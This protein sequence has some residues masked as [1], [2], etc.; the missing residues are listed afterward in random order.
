MWLWTP[1]KIEEEYLAPSPE[2]KQL[3]AA[4]DKYYEGGYDEYDDYYLKQHCYAELK[5]AEA[6][7]HRAQLPMCRRLKRKGITTE[8]FRTWLTLRLL[9]HPD[10]HHY[11]K[12]NEYVN[13]T[14]EPHVEVYDRIRV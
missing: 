13:E 3:D 11:T 9:N 4:W 8:E 1:E 12:W 7:I 10:R 14:V 5:E 6:V 2:R